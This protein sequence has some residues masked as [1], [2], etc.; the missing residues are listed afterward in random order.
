M[1][2]KFR[3]RAEDEEDKIKTPDMPEPLS[4]PDAPAAPAE[5]DSASV[6]EK[7]W[8]LNQDKRVAYEAKLR[9]AEQRRAQPSISSEAY[10]IAAD[11]LRQKNP[12]AASE[13]RQ[14][15]QLTQAQERQDTDIIKQ[16][17]VQNE[18]NKIN[19]QR[20]DEQRQRMKQ[21]EETRRH[22]AQGGET[23]T[24]PATGDSTIAKH[25]DGA[26]KFKPGPV[27]GS[28]PTYQEFQTRSGH[29]ASI[30]GGDT[31]GVL[32]ATGDPLQAKGFV[33]QEMRDDRDKVAIVPLAEKTDAKTGETYVESKDAYG[34]DARMTTGTDPDIQR[35]LKLQQD[36]DKNALELQN[37]DIQN[38]KLEPTFKPIEQEYKKTKA[39]IDTTPDF[40][41]ENGQWVENKP[42]GYYDKDDKWVDQPKMPA[43][44]NKLREWRV[45]RDAEILQHRSA[46]KA[47][48]ETAPQWEGLQKRKQE[49]KLRLEQSQAQKMR[50]DL[51]LP[52]EDGGASRTLA[53]AESGD[54][55]Y[56]EVV[57]DLFNQEE[58]VIPEQASSSGQIPSDDDALNTVQGKSNFGTAPDQVQASVT[59]LMPATDDAKL[60]SYLSAFQG[61]QKPEQFTL[62]AEGVGYREIQRD[63]S[64]VGSL[65]QHPKSKAAFIA[66]NNNEQGNKDL[67][68]LIDIGAKD[69]IPV[70]IHENATPPDPVAEAQWVAG[71]YS[72]IQSIGHQ[73]ASPEDQHKAIAAQGADMMS[74]R[75][76]MQAGEISIQTASALYKDLYGIDLKPANYDDPATFQRYLEETSKQEITQGI[77]PGET[78]ADKWS[79]VS[80]RGKG[81]L[82]VASAAA[83]QDFS[84]SG[85][86]QVKNDYAADYIAKN[87]ISPTFTRADQKALY[88]KNEEHNVSIADHLV[89]KQVAAAKFAKTSVIGSSVGVAIGLG[90]EAAYAEAAL[91]SENARKVL[92]E[93]LALRYG[94]SAANMQGM[95]RN[96]E[97]WFTKEGRDTGALL[98]Q[99][100]SAYQDIIDR[101]EDAATP[102][103]AAEDA[104]L[105]EVIKQGL[106]LHDLARNENDPITERHL[107]PHQDKALGLAIAR[108]KVTA[109]PRAWGLFKSRLL[110]SNDRRRVS[111]EMESRTKGMGEFMT[112]V[113]TGMN[114]DWIEAGS[115]ALSV[116]TMGG[117]GAL[118]K[119]GKAVNAALK[120]NRVYKASRV[121]NAVTSIVQDLKKSAVAFKALGTA[122]STLEKPLSLAQKAGNLSLRAGKGIAIGGGSEA[123]EEV[124]V[125][126]GADTPDLVTAAAGGLFGGVVMLPIG[127]AQ[128]QVGSGL[129]GI[130]G[131]KEKLQQ[132][133]QMQQ[134]FH[135]YARNYNESNAGVPGFE[136]I[137]AKTAEFA[138]LFVDPQQRAADVQNIQAQQQELITSIAQEEQKVAGG[139][140][141]TPLVTMT[142]RLEFLQQAASAVAEMDIAAIDSV[143]QYSSLPTEERGKILAY[144]KV[145]SGRLDAL[146]PEERRTIQAQKTDEGAPMFA[147]DIFTQEGLT[148][149]ARK[150]PP[151][152]QIPQVAEQTD[153]A[154]PQTTAPNGQPDPNVAPELA[155]G[156]SAIAGQEGAN[157][158]RVPV[159]PEIQQRASTVSA[160]VMAAVEQRA[161]GLSS[162]LSI[163]QS[164]SQD[165]SGGV[166]TQ[167]ENILLIDDDI[168]QQLAANPDAT[169]EQI[170]ESLTDTVV[171]HEVTHVGQQMLAVEKA[172]AAGDQ[173]SDSE[174][175]KAHGQSFHEMVTAENPELLDIGAELYARQSTGKIGPKDI[176]NWTTLQPWQQ[177]AEIERMFVEA[178]L[179]GRTT[180][181]NR[182]LS[183]AYGKVKEYLVGLASDLVS[184]IK[185]GSVT[186][187]DGK[188]IQLSDNLKARIQETA[189]YV[190]Q[191]RA[192]NA[193]AATNN[194]TANP[195]N[196][197]Q[198]SA[199]SQASA[200]NSATSQGNSSQPAA[201]NGGTNAAPI[202]QPGAPAVAV[203]PEVAASRKITNERVNFL[204][205]RSPVL[206]RDKALTDE[207]VGIA[208]PLAE[209]IAGQSEAAQRR[210]V[211]NAINAHLLSPEVAARVSA[212]HAAEKGKQ[213]EYRAAAQ[214]RVDTEAGKT[215]NTRMKTIASIMRDVGRIM[216]PPS[217]LPFLSRKDTASEDYQRTKKTLEDYAAW[218]KASDYPGGGR[219]AVIRSII[220]SMM[221]P[222]SE[223][224]VT[225]DDVEKGLEAHS[226]DEVAQKV[227]EELRSYANGT[228]ASNLDDPDADLTDDQI[229]A[230]LARN[231]KESLRDKWKEATGR[232]EIFT[233]E[234]NRL[235]EEYQKIIAEEGENEFLD[236]DYKLRAIEAVAASK[237][238][239]NNRLFSPAADPAKQSKEWTPDEIADLQKQYDD[240]AKDVTASFKK[241]FAPIDPKNPF[242]EWIGSVIDSDVIA[243]Y[244][245]EN[246]NGQADNGYGSSEGIGL[247]IAKDKSES[248]MFGKSRR[249][250]FPKPK[251]AL[252]VDEDA[253]GDTI[254]MLNEES[255]VWQRIFSHQPSK[256][257][258]DWIK[259]HILAAKRIGMTEETWGEKIDDLPRAITDIM[260]H[261]GYD[262]VYVRSGGMEWVNILAKDGQRHNR[263]TRSQK[264]ESL[265]SPSAPTA[266]ASARHAELEARKDS[267]TPEEIKSADPFTGVPLSERFN[268]ESDSILRSPAAPAQDQQAVEAALKNLAP[269]YLDVLKASQETPTPNPAQLAARFSIPEKAVQNILA[270]A[271]AR[272]RAHLATVQPGG[273]QAETLPDG[274]LKGGMPHRAYS[275]DPGPL[276]AVDQLQQQEGMPLSRTNGEIRTAAKRIVDSPNAIPMLIAAAKEGS[277][278]SEQIAAA[279]TLLLAA[280]THGTS[281][282]QITELALLHRELGSQ[283]SEEG[284]ARQDIHRTPAERNAL[285]FSE[286][287]AT[288]DKPARKAY[289]RAKNDTERQSILQAWNAKVRG[290]KDAMLARGVDLDA[291]MAA[292]GRGID[293]MNEAQAE[294]SARHQKLVDALNEE[295]SRLQRALA[296]TQ[297]EASKAT[298][299]A[300]LAKAQKA[301]TEAKA[302]DPAETLQLELSK[303]NPRDRAVIET[304]LSGGTFEQA[305]TVSGLTTKE[306]KSIFSRM[307]DR[308]EEAAVRAAEMAYDIMMGSSETLAAPATL[309]APAVRPDFKAI[310]RAVRNNMGFNIAAI[311]R[312]SLPATTGKKSSKPAKAEPSMMS[313]AEFERRQNT[314]DEHRSLWQFDM[315]VTRP[316]SRITFDEWQ[317]KPEAKAMKERQQ[318]M[319]KQPVSTTTGTLDM[320]DLLSVKRAYDML[321]ILRSSWFDKAIDFWRMAIL[322]G[323]HTGIVNF[324]GNVVHSAYHLGPRRILEAGI[325][326]ALGIIGLGSKDSATL[327]EL[328][329][330][331]K[332]TQIALSKAGSDMIRSWNMDDRVV[333]QEVLALNKQIDFSGVGADYIPRALGGK[334][335]DVMHAISYRHMT[336]ADEMLKS[337]HGHMEVMAFAY[338]MAKSEKLT[339]AEFDKRI[340]ELLEYGSPAWT[341]AYKSAEYVT[342]QSRPEKNDRR[343]LSFLDRFAQAVRRAATSETDIKRTVTNKDGKK[344]TVYERKANALSFFFTFINTPLNIF[345]IGI[346]MSPV[347]A[348]FSIVD[349]SR[350]LKERIDKKH[351]SP[352]AAQAAASELYNK[353]RLV[354]D[355]TNQVIAAGAFWALGSLVKGDDDEPPV[356]TGS[357]DWKRTS[358]GA[359]DVEY[360]VMPPYSIRIGD[361]Y[362][363]YQRVEPFGTALGLLI[364]LRK[365]V[366][367]EGMSDKA[368]GRFLGTFINQLDNKT[369]LKGLSDIFNVAHDPERFGSKLVSGVVT[370]FIPNLIRQPIREADPYIRD[371]KP[372]QEDGF[373]TAVAKSVGYSLTPGYA[374]PQMDVWG[375]PVMRNNGAQL[376]TPQTDVLIRVFDPLNTTIGAKIDPLDLYLFKWNSQAEPKDR[377]N[378]EAIQKTLQ[379]THNGQTY[380]LELTPEEHAAANRAA[381]QAAYEAL[382]STG[383]F[384]RK[385]KPNER[386]VEYAKDIV[387]RYQTIERDRL[388]AVKLREIIK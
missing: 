264:G 356:I 165:V 200:G 353:A 207:L 261:M 94:G 178:I 172:R 15:A 330:M 310:G 126:L 275:A 259:A 36:I 25:E 43:D 314:P 369:Y 13:A 278:T 46:A 18:Q 185:T 56:H 253:G 63:G 211:D 370:G 288:P 143:Q 146:T 121:G 375:N 91:F 123:T 1:A 171:L 319:W 202:E 234:A 244:R 11:K 82:A 97:K 189:A 153:P 44:P 86:E 258:S 120:G 155:P 286:T 160:A 311:E 323:P 246:G 102:D 33:G 228:D 180:D 12:Q 344:V 29:A 215:V 346:E 328:R 158:E 75:N 336:A 378:M 170:I 313:D 85:Q 62:G 159:A 27:E 268:L 252:I 107:D 285:I 338:R 292:A 293:D 40:I 367:T 230:A 281:S 144:A 2:D 361:S 133:A 243:G 142:D 382:S 368:L 373:L 161:P 358:K 67:K 324:G 303:L 83:T 177:G 296:A 279:N 250:H 191:L 198:Q 14:Q 31:S 342:Y 216:R 332:R 307:G 54:A 320:H 337:F 322:S 140:D 152:T 118:T 84:L 19:K 184:L 201:S 214:A 226:Q 168:A 208:W 186:T 283:W 147:G 233:H 113:T 267:L 225:L 219:N 21:T 383:R 141:A 299:E 333:E 10:D 240:Q 57:S 37:L 110:M 42:F 61:I 132:K 192:Q 181:A 329:H 206:K 203:A 335:G 7:Q 183:A 32:G 247:Y 95:E 162:R 316:Q 364:D 277:L 262:A 266:Q 222:D 35:K 257:D 209:S 221:A 385:A 174:I 386:D 49:T 9:E 223:S 204:L 269:I 136:S 64:V 315:A 156:A 300:D 30:L 321:H 73:E 212:L 22:A 220:N 3:S 312:R 326:D 6:R 87:R 145:A 254:P 115:E 298:T 34:Q 69:G 58:I 317:A 297:D 48:E 270:G 76:K 135:A 384:T 371:T 237:A 151:L 295:V 127:L 309:N 210:S 242:G 294:A 130:A 45:K 103:K 77:R 175:L 345:K 217:I 81:A 88:A 47:Y 134:A 39:A 263:G 249:V 109:D 122:E 20:E 357:T 59:H 124:V 148:E 218:P 195:A 291:A 355:L 360:R 169:D 28:K 90:R 131:M 99:A 182:F 248:G 24:D 78:T 92:T 38:L 55:P 272:I 245:G 340:D 359:R 5:Q 105:K 365:A 306:S 236:D 116:L 190:D 150:Y 232:K 41:Q 354:Q 117:Y 265:Y 302:L 80:T 111:L 289:A 348:L 227:A 343:S 231:A 26:P 138:S 196:S 194:S 8:N 280:S 125:E 106:A 379:A 334:L 173:R 363:S 362:F 112:A 287:M 65:N 137:D 273:L 213:K 187:R 366:E 274:H 163:G 157:Y 205:E 166:V 50:L 339:G 301:A 199:A 53:A 93:N 139:A 224:G 16:A 349:A 256:T 327:G 276:A 119:A 193:P 376:G 89:S 347:G 304:I 128:E 51:G 66:F 17:P 308:L 96:F 352:Q 271:R 380:K 176:S 388:R 60:T 98:D 260:L 164:N 305:A 114:A 68:S 235:E 101:N 104:A 70:Y 350:A 325:N 284:R 129:A 351:I 374:P 149:I 282:P 79:K 341:K 71:I 100:T 372:D 167:G 154:I 290:L 381:G 108:Y 4:S 179:E 251:R 387:R 377:F 331:A 74:I 255:D 52:E 229:E 239:A 241:A 72:E 197:Q 23:I 318:R 238:R 188:T